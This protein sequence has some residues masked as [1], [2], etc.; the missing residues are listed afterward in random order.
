MDYYTKLTMPQKDIR[1]YSVRRID[2]TNYLEC[3]SAAVAAV[4][5]SRNLNGPSLIEADVVRLFPH[6]SS[7]DQKKYRPIDQLE[8][9]KKRD[10][11]ILFKDLLIEK[12]TLTELAYDELVKEVNDRV[13]EAVSWAETAPNPEPESA[14]LHVFSDAINNSEIEYNNFGE[15][16][17]PIVMVD[18]INHALREE[19]EK[20]P[21]V[22]VFG[23]D[24][25]DG[26]GG[27]FFRNK[28]F[29]NQIWKR[30]SV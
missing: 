13:D 5:Y 18:A 3:N 7:D 20:N 15:E 30:A 23:E 16:G 14:S 28:R 9:D 22:Y 29:V 2:G 25:A 10:P 21:K 24:I 17:K 12:G 26:K 6:S 1:I 8:A 27:S 19:M 11:I 4:K